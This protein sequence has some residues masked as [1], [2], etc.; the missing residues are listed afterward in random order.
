MTEIEKIKDRISKGYTMSIYGTRENI[1]EQMVDD[2]N[3]LLILNE[4]LNIAIVSNRRELLKAYEQSNNPCD[5]DSCK[6]TANER[7]EKYLSL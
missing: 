5:C 2:I 3:S 1:H 7:V 4:A 6:E